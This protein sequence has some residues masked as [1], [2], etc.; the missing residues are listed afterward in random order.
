M[1]MPEHAAENFIRQP[2]SIDKVEEHGR[3]IIH[4]TYLVK[5]KEKADNFILQRINIHVFKR[6]ELI[7]HNLR[8]VCEHLYALE[9]FADP[10]IDS[11][12]K[13]LH[14]IPTRDKRDFFIDSKKSCKSCGTMCSIT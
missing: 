3:G 11:S 12:W 7:M 9:K 6:P 13:T 4:D 8:L 5:L 1:I 2:E 10:R 14:I